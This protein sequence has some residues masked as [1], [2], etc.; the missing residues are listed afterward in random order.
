MKKGFTLI[1]I[2]AIIILLSVIAL[3]TYPIINNLINDSK[4]ELHEK[5][6]SELNRLTQVWVTKNIN[7]LKMEDGYSYNVSFSELY[8]QGLVDDSD[9]KDPK[10]GED[11]PG[12]MVIAYNANN[13][14]Y[15]VSYDASCTTFGE[16]SKYTDNSGANAPELHTNM[17]PI[18]YEDEKWVVANLYKKWYD[19]DSKEWANAVV[20]TPGVKKNIGD[21]VTEEEIA[22]WYVWVPRYK[23]TIFNGNNESADAQLI[24]ISFE[25]GT[26]RTGTVSCTY[27]SDGS[28][29]CT[30]AI[31]GSIINGTSTYTHPAFKFG[32]Q[33]LKG[34]WFGKFEVSNTDEACNKTNSNN[35]CNKVLTAVTK[36]NVRSW[37]Y[38]SLVNLFTSIANINS[39]YNVSGDSHIVKNM[40]WGAVA[41]LKQS[42][43]GLGTADI[44]INNNSSTFYTG[45]G[46]DNIYKT[47]TNQ[48]TTGN[49]YGIYDMSG[50][51]YEY[52][53]GNMLKSNGSMS[54]SD[55]GFTTELD[56]K[57]YD[58]YKYSTA[59]TSHE[60]SKLGD[61]CKETL[62]TFGTKNAGWYDD[63]SYMPNSYQAWFHRGGGAGT[64]AN[65]GI[66]AFSDNDGGAITNITTRIVLTK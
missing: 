39:T 4:D 7:K 36:P 45:S 61:A 63:L 24:N 9:V 12:C 57:Y 55:S 20:L 10:T 34:F 28:E 58:T 37:R 35:N 13:S 64:G 8:E 3:I 60:R 25:S 31:N 42:K 17:I 6:I 52:V 33:E 30:D 11:L 32:E 54:I 66:F 2:I 49:I 65:A 23:Y 48:S 21:E 27:N 44:A 56:S 29:T 41:Y 46:Q 62:K 15:D 14:G 1:E 5:Q 40:D 51:T 50:G 47:R 38:V 16:G 19:Y 22:L 26:S 43:Y 18:K 53:M 59:Y